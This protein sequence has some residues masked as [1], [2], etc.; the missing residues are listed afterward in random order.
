MFGGQSFILIRLL[1]VIGLRSGS[2]T[3]IVLLWNLLVVIIFV[4]SLR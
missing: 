1:K 2:V 3:K 4:T